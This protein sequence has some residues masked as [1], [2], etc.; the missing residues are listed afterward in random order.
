MNVQRESETASLVGIPSVHN[1]DARGLLEASAR[2]L[3]SINSNQGDFTNWEIDTWIKKRPTGED[4]EN[5]NK[6]IDEL[7]KQN[8]IN[9]SDSIA[10]A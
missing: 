4:I 6:V 7:M 9:P 5:N 10:G 1:E 8:M 2:I 3:V